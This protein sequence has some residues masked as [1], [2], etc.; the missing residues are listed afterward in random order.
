MKEY[1]SKRE[2]ETV[3]NVL[4]QLRMKVWIYA[5]EIEKKNMREW[6]FK[7]KIGLYMIC[8][9]IGSPKVIDE[10]FRRKNET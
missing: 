10:I 3:V 7:K 6:K 5:R 8:K 4:E 2:K 1:E 9:Y